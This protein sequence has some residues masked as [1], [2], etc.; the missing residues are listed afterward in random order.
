MIASSKD[1][2]CRIATHMILVTKQL[3]ELHPAPYNPRIISDA[4]LRG[5]R[6]SIHRYGLVEP[7]IYNERTG[8]VVGGHQ[9][10]LVL[11][12]D[13]AA[14]TECVVVDLPEVEEKA[15]N[16]AL[17]NPAI[18]GEFTDD[19][20]NI[21]TQ[22][23]IDLPEVVFDLR[24]DTLL[25]ELDFAPPAAVIPQEVDTPQPPAEPI[26]KCGDL[27]KLG[28]HR[29]LCGDATNAADRNRLLKNVAPRVIMIDPPYEKDDLYQQTIPSYEAGK[30]LLLHWE[31]K[32]VGIAV[33]AALEKGWPLYTELIW[34]TVISWYTDNRPLIR[35]RS[36][37]IFGDVPKW[38]SDR[39]IIYDGK[40]R[41]AKHIEKTHYGA[42]DYQPLEGAVHLGTVTAIN[43]ASEC[44]GLSYT[45][46]VAWLAAI[47][48]GVGGGIVYDPFGGSGSMLLACEYT[49]DT[50]YSTEIDPG[51]CDVII[52]RWESMTGNKACL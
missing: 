51:S 42:Y 11:K 14:E 30:V 28:K 46:P 7:I 22:L 35:H 47:L 41:T 18:A 6:E 34:D 37:G 16:I 50:C 40:Q 32:G 44:A 8:H 25:Q 24:L 17:N 29:L 49:G 39:A 26:C 33:K 4:A 38:D 52:A 21:I 31:P 13:G 1:I 45:K 27:W 15:L 20:R 19:L 5:L 43:K 23:E 9:R 10:L 3:S 12:A 2:R 36:C 48:W